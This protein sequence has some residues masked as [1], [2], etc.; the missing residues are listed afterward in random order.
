MGEPSFDFEATWRA[1]E[2]DDVADPDL[3]VRHHRPAEGRGAHPPQR[4]G[5]VPRRGEPPP[6]EPGGRV[7]SF[8]PSA[9]IADRWSSH[10]QSLIVFGFTI[11]CLADPRT[12]VAPCPRC[13]PT[14]WGAVPRIW[15]KLKAGL[16][17]QG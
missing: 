17:A 1:V 5:R 4:D 3:H 15:E 7:I 14:A 2:P 8:L 9:H 13:G 16:E 12:I 6:T 11:T 10:Y